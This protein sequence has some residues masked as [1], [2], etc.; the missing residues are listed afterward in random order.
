MKTRGWIFLII[1]GICVSYPFALTK[2][3]ERGWLG[4]INDDNKEILGTIGDL[5]GGLNALFSG[6]G[7]AVLILT[8]I[9][10]YK[11]SKAQTERNIATINMQAFFNMFD[12]VKTSIKSSSDTV[13]AE[14]FCKSMREIVKR[15]VAKRFGDELI[16]P[17]DEKNVTNI[18]NAYLAWEKTFYIFSFVCFHLPSIEK[19]DATVDIIDYSSYIKASLSTDEILTLQGITYLMGANH[20]CLYMKDD[21]PYYD[22]LGINKEDNTFIAEIK[23]TIN[24]ALEGNSF[25]RQGNI[26]VNKEELLREFIKYFSIYEL[27]RQVQRQC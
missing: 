2:A 17:D 19:D 16:F 24:E 10:Q 21:N 8:I 6:L 1:A 22:F 27:K 18:C 14:V 7:F 9:H 13:S 3:L 15:F 25:C 26:P 4:F 23:Q 11:D 5:F 20:G 12:D